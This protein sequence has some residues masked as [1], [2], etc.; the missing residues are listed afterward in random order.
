[1]EAQDAHGMVDACI[2]NQRLSKG[3]LMLTGQ[4]THLGSKEGGP[5]S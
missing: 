4:D 5:G 3:S 1:M 2:E